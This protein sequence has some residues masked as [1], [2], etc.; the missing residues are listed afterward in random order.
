MDDVGAADRVLE[1]AAPGDPHL[2]EVARAGEHLLRRARLHAGAE[3]REDAR[4]GP[5]EQRGSRAQPPRRCAS[6]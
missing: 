3:D 1:L 6:R 4:V 2:G 5:R